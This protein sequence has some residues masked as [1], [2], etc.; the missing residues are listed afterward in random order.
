MRGYI[1][2]LSKF[3]STSTEELLIKLKNEY[4]EADNSQQSSWEEL[5]NEVKHNFQK[6]NINASIII[7]IEFMLPNDGMVLDLGFFGFNDIDKKIGV[8]VE[9]KRWN[10]SYIRSLDFS[11]YREYD[12]M[13][14][15]KIQ[16]GRQVSSFVDY[17]DIG[18]EYNIYPFVFINELSFSDIEYLDRQNPDDRYK[19]IPIKNTINNILQVVEKKIK[20]SNIEQIE[21]ICQSKYQP[22][23][24]I[25]CAMESIITKQNPFILT[26]KQKNALKKV[27]KAFDEGKKIVRIKGPAGSGKTAILLHLYVNYLNSN[28]DNIQS[29]F[30]TGAQNTALYRN[31]YK[32]VERSFTYSFSLDRMVPKNNRSLYYILMDEAQH[33]QEGII[34]NMIKRGCNLVLSYDLGQTI[35]ANNSSKELSIIEKRDDFVSIELEELVRFNGS[36]KFEKNIKS[37]LKGN[38]NFI[39]DDKY[40]FRLFQKQND[41]EKQIINKIKNEPNSTFAVVGLLSNDADKYANHSETK[42]FTKWGYKEECKWM[43]YVMKKNYLSYYDGKIWVGTWWMPGLDVDYVAVIVGGDAYLTNSGIKVNPTKAKHYLMMISVAKEM[44]LPERLIVYKNWSG[45]QKQDNYKSSMRILEYINNLSD[46]YVKKEFLDRFSKLIHNNYY[47]M[48]TR[49]C[50]GCYVYFTDN[51]I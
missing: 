11:K 41:F 50:K 10:G 30:I 21:E 34:T 38:Q 8:F 14:H 51:R 29:I 31:L 1:N 5:I 27:Y 44:K 43:P 28:K 39:Y 19:D 13:L 45:K 24:N 9:T 26:K 36:Q 46:N 4:P 7:V 23:K 48:M 49:G 42:F 2:T 33:N 17:L 15:P 12:T 35:N 3:I 37:L 20:F 32:E 22:S 40:D 18:F 16:V 47:I 25:I 6:H